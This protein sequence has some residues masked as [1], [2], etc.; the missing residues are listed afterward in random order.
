MIMTNRYCKLCTIQFGVPQYS[1]E[2]ICTKCKTLPSAEEQQ[3]RRELFKQVAQEAWVSVSKDLPTELGPVLLIV[4]GERIIGRFNTSNKQFYM[5]SVSQ[6]NITKDVTHWAALPA[7]PEQ[8][9]RK[10]Q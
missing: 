8:Q 2:T 6:I 7:M 9:A 5:G 1:N 4:D 3:E 10:S